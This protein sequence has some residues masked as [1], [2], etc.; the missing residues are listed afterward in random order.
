MASAW[1]EG[2]CS[3]WA[4]AWGVARRVARRV[5]ERAKYFMRR[6]IRVMIEMLFKF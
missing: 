2:E 1:E 3:S 4:R 5:R 6:G